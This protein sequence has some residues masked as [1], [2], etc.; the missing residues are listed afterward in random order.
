MPSSYL[1]V[2]D[3]DSKIWAV[4]STSDLEITLVLF[5]LENVTEKGQDFR[6]CQLLNEKRFLESLPDYVDAQFIDG[7]LRAYLNSSAVTPL[8]TSICVTMV[9]I[10]TPMEGIF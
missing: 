9:F 1:C 3:D 5:E 8:F 6:N 2:S 10:S 7:G 4:A